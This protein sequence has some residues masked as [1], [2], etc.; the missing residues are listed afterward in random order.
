MIGNAYPYTPAMWLADIKLASASGFDGFALNVGTDSWQSA[1]V[2]LAYA[3]AAASGLD[4][5]LFL[6]IDFT[7]FPCTSAVHA[8][9][10]VSLAAL[11]A[12]HS[13]QAVYAGTDRPLLSTFA[14]SDCT[15]GSADWNAGF[16]KEVK[17]PLLAKSGKEMF[18][19]PSVFTD[20]STF[21]SVDVMD[22]ELNWNGGWPMGNT[23]ISFASDETYLKGLGSKALMASVSPGFFTHYSPSS[24]NKNWIFLSDGFLYAKRWELLVQ[25][26]DKVD[27]VEAVTWNDYGESSYVGPI[28]G[29]QPNSEAWVDGFDHTP[30]LD[31]NKYYSEAFKTGSFPSIT[32]DKVFLTAR[33]HHNQAVATADTMGRPTGGQGGPSEGYLWAQNKFF[34]FVLATDDGEIKLQSGASTET[35]TVKKGANFFEMDLVTGWGMSATLTRNSA[36]VVSLKPDYTFAGSTKIYNWNYHVYSN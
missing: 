10:V 9:A 3:A 17:A 5:K 19:V 20:P 1:Q 25:N 13:N 27:L 35:F 2:A 11:Y 4:F 18:F 16:A 28:E 21:A 31:I 22:G 36:T 26:R 29:A 15:F 7:V 32:A 24:W 30:L 12:S 8:T 34:A 33:P 6:S 23:E 14:G